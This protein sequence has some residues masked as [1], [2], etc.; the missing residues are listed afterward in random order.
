MVDSDDL[1]KLDTLRPVLELLSRQNKYCFFIKKTNIP[2]E[3]KM[4]ESFT[5]VRA[6]VME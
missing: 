4:V 5:T 6:V 3:L 2:F 1:I